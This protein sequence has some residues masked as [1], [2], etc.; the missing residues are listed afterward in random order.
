MNSKPNLYVCEWDNGEE[1]G[2]FL[3]NSEY[4]ARSAFN[5]CDAVNRLR[6]KYG[7]KVRLAWI[8]RTYRVK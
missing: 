6:F 5:K 1:H 3:F 8:K 4:K 2:Q 7:D